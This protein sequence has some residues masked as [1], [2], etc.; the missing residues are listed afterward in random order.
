M[1]SLCIKYQ[2]ILLKRETTTEPMTIIYTAVG[3]TPPHTSTRPRRSAQTNASL[4]TRMIRPLLP[5]S[6]PFVRKTPDPQARLKPIYCL[7]LRFGINQLY[8]TECRSGPLL[9]PPVTDPDT[10]VL[11]YSMLWSAFTTNYSIPQTPLAS[12]LHLLVLYV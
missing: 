12:C 1:N 8:S 6:R 2:H 5:H 9:L 3:T 4:S 10:P 11:L 7:A